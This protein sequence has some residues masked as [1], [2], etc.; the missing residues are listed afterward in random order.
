[1][2][3]TYICTISSNSSNEREYEVSTRS[4]MKAAME[5]GRCEGGET[6]TILTKGGKPI[7]R[8]IW[9]PE[10]GGKYIRVSLFAD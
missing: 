9:H 3:Q 8:V 5:F 4:A 6:V 1:M 7:S 2:Q 10:Q